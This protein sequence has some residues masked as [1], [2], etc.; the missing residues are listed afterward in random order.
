M[1]RKPVIFMYHLPE[2]EASAQD[3]PPHTIIQL[4]EK[5]LSADYGLLSQMT[6][7]SQFVTLRRAFTEE[8]LMKLYPDAARVFVCTHEGFEHLKQQLRENGWS[9]PHTTPSFDFAWNPL[10]MLAAARE[11]RHGSMGA[12]ALHH[13]ARMWDEAK[14]GL[15]RRE[16]KFVI[17]TDQS[18][19]M[20]TADTIGD[21]EL[22][23][24][25]EQRIRPSSDGESISRVPHESDN[26]EIEFLNL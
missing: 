8:R 25:W 6:H 9:I 5:F 2:N 20:F 14:A 4:G 23:D 12:A 17:T 3:N 26:P 10:E 21:Y 18:R 16:A 22:M 13:V 1:D 15:D 19:S 7:P 24:V 11:C